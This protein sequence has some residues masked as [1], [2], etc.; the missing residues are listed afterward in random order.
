M[1]GRSGSGSTLRGVIG[2][3]VAVVWLAFASSASADN[4]VVLYKQNAVPASAGAD[5]QRAG[6]S[7]VYGYDQI[8][9]SIA[10]SSSSSFAASLA[11]DSG[12]DGVASTAGCASRRRSRAAGS[13]EAA[14]PPSGGLPN[15]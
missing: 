2:A 11:R 3:A 10:R 8:G 15:A 7:L 12:V 6:G 13:G 14:G 5:I 4:F 9:V 1:R